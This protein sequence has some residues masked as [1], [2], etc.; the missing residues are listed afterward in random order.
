MHILTPVPNAGLHGTVTINCRKI[1]ASRASAESFARPAL[2]NYRNF[3]ACC[4]AT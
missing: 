1:R 3:G 4:A 2:T